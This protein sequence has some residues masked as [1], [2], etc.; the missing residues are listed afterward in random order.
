M[1]LYTLLALMVA[2][3]HLDESKAAISEIHPG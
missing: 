1:K 3:T 2:W